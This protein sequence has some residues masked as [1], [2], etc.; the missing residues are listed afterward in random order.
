MLKKIIPLLFLTIFLLSCES[1]DEKNEK[2]FPKI[3]T[4]SDIDND[5][6]NDIDDLLAGARNEIKN[7]TTYKS[8]YYSGGYPPKNEWVCTDVIW[9]A[10]KN[11]WFNLKEKLDK[12]IKNHLSDYKQIK[13]KPDSNIDFR[14]VPNL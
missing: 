10:F 6:I 7:K 1:I 5:W 9:R 3:T 13:G 14:R 4:I 8:K 2:K 12:D 11:I